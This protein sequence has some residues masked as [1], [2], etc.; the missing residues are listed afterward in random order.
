MAGRSKKSNKSTK[1]NNSSRTKKSI[2]R[3]NYGGSSKKRNY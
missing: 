3:M 2:R 1:R